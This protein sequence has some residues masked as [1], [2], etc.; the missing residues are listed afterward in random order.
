MK[1]SARLL[2]GA[3]LLC[4]VLEPSRAG[5]ISPLVARMPGIRLSVL[6]EYRLGVAHNLHPPL[7]CFPEYLHRFL[8]CESLLLQSMVE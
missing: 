7:G 3:S 6:E 1:Q 2:A 4:V 8:A 5:G